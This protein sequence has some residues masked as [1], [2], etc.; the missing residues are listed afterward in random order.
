MA[1]YCGQNYGA[2]KYG[3]IKSGMKAV[4]G[5]GLCFYVVVVFLS[6][7]VSPHLVGFVASTSDSEVLY[8][9][10]TYLKCNMSFQAVCVLIVILRNSMQ[11]FGDQ[12][13]P[14]VSSFIELVAK[15]V[16]TF[17]FVKQ[18]GYWGV[19]WTEPVAWILMVIPLIVMTLKNP[20]MEKSLAG[21]K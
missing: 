1:T 8:W 4:L 13:T 21:K 15:I 2:G 6:F 20:V 10:S 9:G 12:K 18:F 14:V 7:T 3:R 16:F 5:I 11:G 19:I 17:I